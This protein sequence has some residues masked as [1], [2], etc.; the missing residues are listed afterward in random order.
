L[1]RRSALCGLAVVASL[2][3]AAPAHAGDPVC[4]PSKPAVATVVVIE[5]GGFVLPGWADLGTCRAL[6][7]HGFRAVN[8]SYPLHDLPGAVSTTMR[9]IRRERRHG[10]PVCALGESS[11]GTLAELAAVEGRAPAVAVA[12]PTNLLDWSPGGAASEREWSSPAAYWRDVGATR[13]ERRAAS[14][15]FRIGTGP[16][17]LLLFHSPKDE[18]VPIAQARSLA[19]KVPGARLKRLRGRHLQSQAFRRPAFAWLR[20]NCR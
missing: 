4:R 13:R 17:P 8:V 12:A 19:S 2:L 20:A 3:V 10:L 11:G 16:S 9:K 18:V 6:A 7:R 5:G 15:I 1:A 14:P